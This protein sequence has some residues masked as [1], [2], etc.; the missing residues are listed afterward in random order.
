MGLRESKRGD[1]SEVVLNP[2]IATTIVLV[3]ILLPLLNF[4]MNLYKSKFFERSFTQRDIALTLDTLQASPNDVSIKYEGKYLEHLS[5]YLIDNRI[6]AYETPKGNDYLTN[7]GTDTDVKSLYYYTKTEDIIIPKKAISPEVL[8]KEKN[9]TTYKEPYEIGFE[10]KNTNGKI[11]ITMTPWQGVPL[12]NTVDTC[13]FIR[14]KD[15]SWQANKKV[16]LDPA[17]DAIHNLQKPDSTTINSW[18][19]A[20]SICLELRDPEIKGIYDTKTQT[21]QSYQV[22]SYSQS[23]STPCSSVE[24][25]YKERLNKP[26]I[27]MLISLDMYSDNSQTDEYRLYYKT[28]S[29]ESAKL[30]CIV[31]TN[32][33]K[34]GKT[35][36]LT[37]FDQGILA[38][39][40]QTTTPAVLIQLGNINQADLT[41]LSQIKKAIQISI[42]EYYE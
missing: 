25:T 30:G 7:P 37:K 17:G 12:Q 21:S 16:F 2:M 24:M 38:D 27:D 13:P 33:E 18:I 8:K 22:T 6:E 23:T 31:K 20:K 3:L 35:V 42:D 29:L 10:R 5:V 19:I 14:T 28:N 32:L 26:R 4:S 1:L 41:K 40:S 9:K 34:I 11:T 15:D 39:L 36:V